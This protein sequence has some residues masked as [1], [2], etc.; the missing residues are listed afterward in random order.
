MNRYFHK[1][2]KNYIQIENILELDSGDGCK[3]CES[4][5]KK[6]K[7]NANFYFKDWL[8]YYLTPYQYKILIWLSVY[9]NIIFTWNKISILEYVL[10]F[11]FIAGALKSSDMKWLNPNI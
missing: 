6:I 1:E 2:Y 7:H 4:S 10:L 8:I 5:K 3:P 9:K 11:L